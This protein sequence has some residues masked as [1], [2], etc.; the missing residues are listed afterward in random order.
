MK[1]YTSIGTMAE[2]N[3]AILDVSLPPPSNPGDYVFAGIYDPINI[4]DNVI[5]I[6]LTDNSSVELTNPNDTLERFI[7][8]LSHLTK[9][10]VT[11]EIEVI[12]LHENTM[13]TSDVENE[14]DTII[15][16]AR[17]GTCNTLRIS[18][19][20]TTPKTCGTGVIKP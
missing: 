2:N 15:E 4:S 5:L 18:L 11:K 20:N 16:N 9:V 1:V 8:D 10:D 13:R 3:K 19:T 12:L 14:A 6:H 7:I 17:V